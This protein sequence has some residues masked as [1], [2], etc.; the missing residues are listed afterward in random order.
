LLEGKNN[1]VELL[2]GLRYHD[3]VTL[4]L[5]YFG[6]SPFKI[7]LYTMSLT[8]VKNYMRALFIAL[9]YLHSF[10]IIHRDIKPN[11]FLYSIESGKFCLVDFGLAQKA[12]EI[13]TEK[14]QQ[15]YIAPIR[16]KLNFTE[17]VILT[18]Q[19]Y[20]PSIS[21]L[22]NFLST[23]IDLRP[24]PVAPRAGTRGFRAPEVLLRC[25]DQ[26]VAI[27]VWAAGVI[28]LTIFSQRYP[29]FFLHLMI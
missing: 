13:N 8:Q 14:F 28:L 2:G 27:D 19:N 7:Y 26:T 12:D 1:I 20:V 16:R 21:S 5:E 17:N 23:N 24:S 29:F 6:H 15:Q 25:N 11:N 10:N 3:Q 4:I 22:P 18:K 9:N